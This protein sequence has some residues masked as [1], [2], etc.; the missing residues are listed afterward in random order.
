VLIFI[1]HVHLR[2]SL[3]NPYAIVCASLLGVIFD[4]FWTFVL[5]LP[6]GI[7]HRRSGTGPREVGVVAGVYEHYTLLC[8]CGWLVPMAFFLYMGKR[9]DGGCFLYRD[10]C[11]TRGPWHGIFVGM[12]GRRRLSWQFLVSFTL[13]V[14]V[15]VGRERTSLLRT[16]KMCLAIS[17]QDDDG[18]N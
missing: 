6:Q 7:Y 18:V 8:C 13:R 15:T 3:A 2:V 4:F 9:D 14:E 5:L 12:C 11:G 10:G 16:Q 1:F 17:T